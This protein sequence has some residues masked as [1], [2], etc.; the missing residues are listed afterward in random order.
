MRFVQVVRKVEVHQALVSS[1][2]K[3]RGIRQHLDIVCA[4]PLVTLQDFARVTVYPEVK[5]YAD[6]KSIAVLAA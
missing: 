5:N 2:G 3:Q 4:F 6:P 1:G